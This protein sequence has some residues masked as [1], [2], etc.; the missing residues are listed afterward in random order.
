MDILTID[1]DPAACPESYIIEETE[2]PYYKKGSP[3]RASLIEEGIA[4]EVFTLSGYVFDKDC[5]PVA[6]AWLD[7]WHADGN[8]HYDNAG[9]RLRGHQFTDKQG[10][11][12]LKTVLPGAYQRRTNHI[13]VKVGKKPGHAAITTQ[14]FFP[15]GKLN[16]TDRMYHESLLITMGKDI[17]GQKV[18]LFN[19]RLNQ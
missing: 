1:F 2:G 19:F 6:G 13:H 11:Y 4:G 18:G 9:Y 8:G 3:E 10:R 5:N 12:I 16:D 14:L 15:E 17:N 7:F